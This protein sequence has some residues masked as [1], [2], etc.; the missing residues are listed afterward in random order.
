MPDFLEGQ[1]RSLLVSGEI[2]PC[3]KDIDFQR[4]AGSKSKKIKTLYTVMKNSLTVTKVSEEFANG[5][6]LHGLT[7]G[8]SGWLRGQ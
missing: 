3:E 5:V 2:I 8:Q 4:V 7:L 6:S 1:K